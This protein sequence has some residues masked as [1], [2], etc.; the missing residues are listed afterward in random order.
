M[1]DVVDGRSLQPGQ[2]LRRNP[3]PVLPSRREDL[4]HDVVRLV[5]DATTRVGEHLSPVLDEHRLE[6]AVVPLQV[7]AHR[8]HTPL[9]PARTELLRACSPRP[10][11]RSALASR[12]GGF[13]LGQMPANSRQP[14]SW[15]LKPSATRR[16]SSSERAA[17][18][19]LPAAVM[20]VAR[21]T[22]SSTPP[23]L[24][25]GQV[26][27]TGTRG[28]QLREIGTTQVGSHS[29]CKNSPE[30]SGR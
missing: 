15:V 1:Q 3:T 20:Y 14:Q 22:L 26:G 16:T 12:R 8:L 4:R 18:N 27:E 29:E 25:L 30:L 28:G 6:L 24:L 19:S 9:A 7:L 10:P 11:P 21:A 13:S 5:R 17:S 23:S 2:R